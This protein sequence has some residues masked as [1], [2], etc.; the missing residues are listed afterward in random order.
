MIETVFHFESTSICILHDSCSDPVGR[1]EDGL[2]IKSNDSDADTLTRITIGPY[3]DSKRIYVFWS[4]VTTGEHF[5]LLYVATTKTLFIGSGS[6]STIINIESMT[7]VNQ[8]DVTLFWSYERR[9][10]CVLELGE[11][12]CFLYD[13]DGNLLGNV[14]ADPPYDLKETERGINVVSPIY[15]SQWLEFPG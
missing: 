5:D 12:E 11:L 3:G 1:S 8:N 13:L 7:L 2:L 9:R 4:L 14:P 6:T 10:N 15:G